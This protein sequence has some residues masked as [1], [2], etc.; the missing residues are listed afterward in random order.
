MPIN[1]GNLAK[2]NF[3]NYTQ[4]NYRFLRHWNLFFLVSY[5][6]LDENVFHKK[7]Y[8]PNLI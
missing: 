6:E 7:K 4:G 5:V 2:G 1:A 3:V 8:H